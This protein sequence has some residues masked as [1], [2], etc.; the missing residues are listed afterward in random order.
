MPGSLVAAFF[1]EAGTVA[2]AATAFAV[3]L[4]ASY[5][6]GQTLAQKYNDRG[7][8]ADT[9]NPGARVQLPPAGDNKL[10]VVYGSAYVG[11]VI[12]DMSISTDNQ[13]MY[14]VL[15]LSEVTNTENGGTGDTFTFGN[16]YYAGK[17][18]VFDS[19][20]KTKITG[21]LDE[22]TGITD[23]TMNGYMNMYLY[24][25]GSLNPTNTTQT[26]IQVMQDPILTYKWD[27]TKLMSNTCFAIIKLKYN[28]QAGVTGLQQTR[29]QVNSSRYAPGDCFYDYFTS[30]RYG[31]AIPVAQI[32]TTSLTA[33]NTYCAGSFTYTTSL[34]GTATQA[35]FRFD[36]A[37]E[38]TQSVMNNLQLMSACCDC[39]I[40]YNEI[41]SL[42]GV[43][44]Q[45]PTTTIAMDIND[46]NMISALSISPMDIANTFNIAE[47]KFPDGSSK[48]SFNSAIY[49]L[50]V[51][52]PSLL[53]PNEPANKQ[54]ISLPL[55]NNS[56]RA[57]YIAYRLLKAVREDLQIQV[58][59]DYEG[60]QLEAGDIVT[61]TNANYG[62]V[63]KQFRV[64]QVTET[65]GD[66]GD[67]TASLQLMEYNATVYNDA[68]ITEFSPS[69]N[70]GIPDPSFFGTVPAP[71]VSNIVTSG[72]KPGFDVTITTSTN[73]VT[74]YAELWYS[75]VPNPT[76]AQL[77]L[78]GTTAVAA[79]G[80]PYATST[81]LTPINLASYPANTYYFYARMRNSLRASTYSLA[82]TPITWNPTYID[83]V[84]V[85][86]AQGT[87][88]TWQ[89]VSNYRLAGYRLRYQYGA[90]TDWNSANNI[91][92]GLI[93]TTTYD[94]A[95]L[96][97]TLLTILIKAVDTA[98]NE[99][100]AA[101]SL[102]I[103]PGSA[104]SQYIVYSYD[105][106]ANGWPGTITNGSIVSGNI[107][108][109]TTD[110]LY[111]DDDQS[112]YGPDASSFYDLTSVASVVYET[113]Q[114]LITSALTGSQGALSATIQG[115]D[116][117]LEYRRVNGTSFYGPDGDSKYGAD[118]DCF[119][120]TPSNYALMPGKLAVAN[121]YYQFRVTVGAGV[122][123][124]IDALTFRVDAPV[125][126]ETLNNYT[127]T[128]GVIS[129]TKS[130]TS[131]QAVLATLQANAL[132]VVTLETDKTNPLA[133]TITG[134]NNSHVAVSGAK[135]DITLQGY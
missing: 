58:R 30:A 40:K 52:D 59:I 108:A 56:V 131:I 106:R 4:V 20:D 103:T 112:F 122:I 48:D 94:V 55:V 135:A 88:L 85:F 134:Y 111:G 27:A 82:S 105:F 120:G 113:S 90:N 66:A 87:V 86:L 129:Y 101:N 1:F 12:T 78:A 73:G 67:V 70:T 132:G 84:L 44:V 42:W 2:Y 17:L 80:N 26:A 127:V 47:V 23:T 53:Y 18:C 91:T 32:D 77:T 75:N 121:D 61:V 62:W 28:Q 29:F 7:A 31:A 123:G 24:S 93:T 110:S 43:I 114:I 72:Y 104:L 16:I 11:G 96:P 39:L 76:S 124:E 35:R 15:A 107:V 71:V 100:V 33:L 50:A 38:T 81:A 79:S 126:T 92:D 14:F 19:V 8:T 116:V 41:T 83:N 45:S 13:T 9:K 125:I 21:L 65:F 97:A 128:G 51:V 133:P 25:R 115:K 98:G 60:L 36:G 89:P 64:G 37:V 54:T 49:D 6:V 119:Y 57:Q 10:P 3:N 130:F 22:S 46:S 5:V 34:G 117:T 74:Q 109:T 118:A 69:A 95:G 102:T 99:S 68:S 63:A